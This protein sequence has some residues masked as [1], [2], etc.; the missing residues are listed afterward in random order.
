MNGIFEFLFGVPAENNRTGK[1]AP[2]PPEPKAAEPTAPASVPHRPRVQLSEIDRLLELGRIASGY[3]DIKAF[4]KP[5]QGVL[6][7]H[8]IYATDSHKAF[9]AKVETPI[10]DVI[11]PF[12]FFKS[13]WLPGQ[14]K[15]LGLTPDR[16]RLV[17]NGQ[18]TTFETMPG[19]DFPRI[20]QVIPTK[21]KH[22]VTMEKA[23]LVDAVMSLRVVG[24]KNA[25]LRF[26][27]RPGNILQIKPLKHDH[28]MTT[29]AVRYFGDTLQEPFGLN[30]NY[31]GR[32]LRDITG[33]TVRIRMNSP[34]NAI[35]MDAGEG[36]VTMLIM[37]IRIQA[38][39]EAVR[40]AA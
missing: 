16:K 28:P 38:D 21:F 35:M 18:V 22:L 13:R 14:I 39:A 3:V 27:P 31:L 32:V 23:K 20:E 8:G 1:P 6:I 34:V 7:R 30:A 26:D 19:A 37:P 33:N 29:Q 24:D 10:N 12:S 11:L 4:G 15:T 25:A 36:V 5:L 9:I 17:I 2:R 40:R